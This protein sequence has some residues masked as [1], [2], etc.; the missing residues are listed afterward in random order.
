MGLCPFGLFCVPARKFS[1]F[2]NFPFFQILK[3]LKI[4]SRNLKIFGIYDI[5]YIESERE[6]RKNLKKFFVKNRV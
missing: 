3:I 2:S 4:T 6:T 1:L 5:L